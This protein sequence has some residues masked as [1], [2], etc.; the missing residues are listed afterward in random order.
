MMVF[1]ALILSIITAYYILY[2]WV[3]PEGAIFQATDTPLRDLEVNRQKLL[4][5]IKDLDLEFATQKIT[6]ED[7]ILQKN[8]LSA[9]LGLVYA[10]IDAHR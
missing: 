9:E 8:A 1:A 6:S 7:Y 2:P 10:S 3:C 4:Q 5:A